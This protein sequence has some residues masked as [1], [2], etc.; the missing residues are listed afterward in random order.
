M[1]GRGFDLSDL[2]QEFVVGSC[3]HCSKFSVYKKARTFLIKL[4]VID[5]QRGRSSVETVN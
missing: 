3:D 4:M 1:K 5:F 2:G